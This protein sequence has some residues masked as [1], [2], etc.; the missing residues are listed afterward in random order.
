M[1]NKHLIELHI[2]TDAGEKAYGAV[3]YI[4]CV[5]DGNVKIKLIGAKSK[6]APLKATSIPRLELEACVLGARFS[7]V[8]HRKPLYKIS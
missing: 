8:H 4:R 2:F 5:E 3:A 6:V 7:K 1:S